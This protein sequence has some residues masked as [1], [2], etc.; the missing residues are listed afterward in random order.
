MATPKKKVSK[1]RRNMRRFA[2]GNALAKPTIQSC[3]ACNEPKRP[4]AVCRCGHYA[5]KTVYAAR[6][7]SKALESA[8][9]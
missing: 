8:E 3:P 9:A 5:G 1:S 7:K 6:K 2:G 4:H